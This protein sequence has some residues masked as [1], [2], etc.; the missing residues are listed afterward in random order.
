ML[1]YYRII[2]YMRANVTYNE[3]IHTVL[4][5]YVYT[6][7]EHPVLSYRYKD[8]VLVHLLFMHTC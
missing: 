7:K 6:M 3:R 5:H 8:S 1:N 4:P 2:G